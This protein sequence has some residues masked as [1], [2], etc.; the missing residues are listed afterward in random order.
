MSVKRKRLLS[1]SV[2]LNHHMCVHDL[3]ICQRHSHSSKKTS[4]L[5]LVAVKDIQYTQINC[6]ILVLIY[7]S[8]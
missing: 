1:V 2:A 3:F 5:K 7:Y 6:D 8:F 4:Q